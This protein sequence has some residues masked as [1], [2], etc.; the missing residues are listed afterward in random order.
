MPK[1]NIHVTPNGN[2]RWQIKQ[3]GAERA[4]AL[5]NT[6]AEAIKHGTA[7]AKNNQSELFIHGRNGTIRER[8]TFGTD[9]H[10]PKG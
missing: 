2:G 10:P 6:Q 4:S 1:K 9:P 5:F 8:N 3:A 7:V